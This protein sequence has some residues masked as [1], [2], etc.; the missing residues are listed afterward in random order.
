M[1]RTLPFAFW[2]LPPATVY[3]MGLVFIAANCYSAITV[4]D[5]PER[6]F[7]ECSWRVERP[8]PDPATFIG[9]GKLDA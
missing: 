3:A 7:D 5:F 9:S 1:K 8:T 2:W 6:F 4:H